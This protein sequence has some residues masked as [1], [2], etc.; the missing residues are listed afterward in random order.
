MS[1][2]YDEYLQQHKANVKKGYDWIKDNL[3]ELIPDGRRL[4]L[5]HQIGFA[6]DYYTRLTEIF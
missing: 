1:K 3:P 6:H 2:Q 4:D 5:E